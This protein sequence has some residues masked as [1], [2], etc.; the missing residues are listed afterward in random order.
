MRYENEIRNPADLRRASEVMCLAQNFNNV[1][2]WSALYFAEG[3]PR[4]SLYFGVGESQVRDPI[5]KK[6]QRVYDRGKLQGS[7]GTESGQVKR[8]ALELASL[9]R[10]TGHTRINLHRFEMHQARRQGG[11]FV[12]LGN[13]LLPSDYEPRGPSDSH[14]L[15]G[16]DGNLDRNSGSCYSNYDNMLVS[17]I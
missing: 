1:T 13:E 5:S 6:I 7:F 9:S 12:E 2:S 17:I 11:S 15:G 3:R 8:A 16:D 4:C 14:V 10:D